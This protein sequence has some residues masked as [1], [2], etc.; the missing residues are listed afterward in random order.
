MTLITAS[1]E[2]LFKDTYEALR[3]SPAWNRTVLVVTY[4]DT[5]GWYDHAGVPVGVPAPDDEKSCPDT[6]DFTWLG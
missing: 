1:G 3:A 4:D 5:G 2:R 6:T